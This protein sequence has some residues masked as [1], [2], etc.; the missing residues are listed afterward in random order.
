MI[1]QKVISLTQRILTTGLKR[2]FDQIN[3]ELHKQGEVIEKTAKAIATKDNRIDVL[4]EKLT[5]VENYQPIYAI[6]GLVDAPARESR[7]RCDVILDALGDV[8]G[9]RILDIGSS[10]GYVSFFFADRGAYVDGWE[11]NLEN[12]EVA[13]LVSGINGVNANLIFLYNN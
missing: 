10:L 12:A 9:M 1:K 13:R 5:H 8:A 2:Q 7:D 3:R 11:S 6:A 4:K